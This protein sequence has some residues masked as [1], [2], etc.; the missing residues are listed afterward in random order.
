MRAGLR[1]LWGVCLATPLLLN[2]PQALAQTNRPWV[3]PPADLK[4]P[5]PAQPAQPAPPPPAAPAPAPE[6][7]P[8]AH[9]ESPVSPAP[10]AQSARPDQTSPTL[11]SPQNDA[12]PERT[13]AARDLTLRYLQSWSSV[14]EEGLD[15]TSEF[16]GPRVLFHGRLV[17]ARNLMREK[18]RFI[19]RWPERSYNAR[20]GTLQVACE[21][22]GDDCAVQAIFD[23][24]AAHPKRGRQAQGVGALQ[25][26]VT[27]VDNQPVIAAE[28]SIVL[29]QGPDQPVVIPEESD[30][31]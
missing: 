27:F 22:Q 20:P 2:I 29:D 7:P 13:Q 26:I 25:L 6:A 19:R 1:H 3:D 10:S 23:F 5:S 31:D 17:S 18:R 15:A 12:R 8:A 30:D 4:A 24:T 16:Y 14:T 11:A 28:S 9:A 21:M